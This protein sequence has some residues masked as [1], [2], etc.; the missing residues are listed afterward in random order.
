MRRY[1]HFA[2]RPYHRVNLWKKA[3]TQTPDLVGSGGHSVEF[4]GRNVS[5]RVLTMRHYIV[6]SEAHAYRKYCE[7]RHYSPAE[8][9]D[10]GWHFDRQKW[11]DLRYRFPADSETRV[12]DEAA[13]L[14]TS[15]PKHHHIFWETTR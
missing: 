5:H 7:E 11:R 14:D 8:V 9:R 6:L 13:P 1:Y 12:L 4:P 10:R 3:A 2:P 15:D